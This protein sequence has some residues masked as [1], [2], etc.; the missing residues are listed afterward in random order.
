MDDTNKISSEG[1]AKNHAKNGPSDDT[2]DTDDTLS[3]LQGHE[4]SDKNLKE[5]LTMSES[6]YRLGHS[7]KW[8]CRN[9]N[10]RDDK[11]GMIKHHC[12]GSI[13]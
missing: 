4:P 5:S 13:H 2:D 11:W 9:C 3:T 10:L 8:A 7:D 1:L 6:I 12:K